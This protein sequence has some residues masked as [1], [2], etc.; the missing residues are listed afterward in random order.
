MKLDNMQL[1]IAGAVLAAVAFYMYSK[2]KNELAGWQKGYTILADQINA[3][4]ATK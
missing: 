2:K 1:A 4:P 3:A